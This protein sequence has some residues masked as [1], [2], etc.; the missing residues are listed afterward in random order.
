MRPETAP[1]RGGRRP[2][3]WN[4]RRRRNGG[5]RGGRNGT[6]GGGH[7][8]P[9]FAALDLGTNN[10]R[11]LIAAPARDGIRVVDSFSRIVRLG[12]GLEATGR[13]AEPAIE[14]TLAALSICAKIMA[15]YPIAAA[16]GVATEAC[17]RA[18]NGREFLDRVFARTGIRLE[19][20]DFQEEA[21]LTLAG[22]APLLD[23]AF[24]YA[25]TFDIGG[26]STELMW[27]DQRDGS[28]RPLGVATMPH[29]VVT[30]LERIG[31]PT[32]PA[33]D[34]ARLVD[35][36]DA[37]LVAFERAHGIADHVSADRVH[38]LGTSG[39]VTTLGGIHLNLK[40]YDRS[41]VDGM[42][43]DFADLEAV[44]ARLAA[45]DCAARARHPC[46]GPDRAD[47][48]LMGCAILAA[49]CRRWPVGRLRVADRGIREG[50][51]LAMM[52]GVVAETHEAPN[53]AVSAA[54]R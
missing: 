50:L 10:C 51:L 46:I 27:I 6:D 38:M 24:P 45:M 8:R 44:S 23:T 12:E 3:A 28:P 18:V 48:V 14:R 11:M 53:P 20:I 47:L 21:A 30:L 7:G 22:C 42:N 16:R 1:G 41:K 15:K 9:L 29:G 49:V 13:L 37:D 31:H 52:K 35:E 4:R 36:I 26:G 34:Y 17:R 32:P 25:L 33:D 19:P 39:T 5:G 54:A 2:M 43:I 40:R